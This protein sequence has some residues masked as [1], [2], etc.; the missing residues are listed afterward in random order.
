M[1]RSAPKKD[2]VKGAKHSHRIG[3]R[4]IPVLDSRKRKVRGL[5]QRNGRFY[6]QMPLMESHGKSRAVRIPLE[7]ARLDHAIAEADSENLLGRGVKE[8]MLRREIALMNYP[9]TDCQSRDNKDNDSQNSP[10]SP[11]EPEGDHVTAFVFTEGHDSE[12]AQGQKVE[13]VGRKSPVH[14]REIRNIR[15]QI[16][17]R[18]GE[19]DY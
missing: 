1:G 7:A 13:I 15:L 10:D 19:G 4:F 12:G 17:R 9:H 14:G 6:A 2:S 3:T 8:P 11:V 18:E 5:V 16:D